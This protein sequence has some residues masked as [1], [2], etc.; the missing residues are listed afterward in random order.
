MREEQCAEQSAIIYGYHETYL[1]KKR[2]FD[3][4]K[5]AMDGKFGRNIPYGD[6]KLSIYNQELLEHASNNNWGLYRNT[7]L[8]MAE[9]LELEDSPRDAL[10]LYLEICYLDING[11][12]NIGSAI[13]HPELLKE[14]PPFDP[15]RGLFAPGIL[16]RIS[17][18]KKELGLDSAEIKKLFYDTAEEQQDALKL[19]RSIEDAWVMLEKEL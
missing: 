16:K 7:K 15:K 6:V 17:R 2:E 10:R 19:S 18:I 3:E 1:A 5:A 9:V 8:Q 12:T 14:Y 11:P 4:E 13:K